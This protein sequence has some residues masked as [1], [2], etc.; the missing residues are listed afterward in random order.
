MDKVQVLIIIGPVGIGKT[1]IADAISEILSEKSIH[2]AVI[3]LDHLRYAFPRP[4]TDWFHTKL[5]YK[6]LAAVWKN[7][8]EVGVKCIIIPNV[9]ED[10]EDIKHIEEAIPGAVV[11]VVRLTAPIETI[12]NRIKGREKSEKSLNWHLNR[13]VELN[14]KLEGKNVE[15]FTVSTENKSIKEIAEE[16]LEKGN[17]PNI[18]L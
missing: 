17:W 9:L 18:K 16:V 7:Y 1:S 8:Q 12:H 2:H 14:N 5:G 10:R 13:A 4:S 6:N 11:T 3:D 15:D